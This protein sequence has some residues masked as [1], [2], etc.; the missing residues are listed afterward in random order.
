MDIRKISSAIL[1]GGLLSGPAAAEQ[2]TK[3]TGAQKPFDR[4]AE[5]GKLQDLAE[6]KCKPIVKSTGTRGKWYDKLMDI[7]VTTSEV[8]YNSCMRGNT[9]IEAIDWT[10]TPD[11]STLAAAKDEETAIIDKNAKQECG[12]QQDLA[13]AAC[14]PTVVSTGVRGKWY[15]KLMD[16]CVTTS[17]ARYNACVNGKKSIIWTWTPDPSMLAAAKDEARVALEEEARKARDTAAAAKKDQ[18]ESAAKANLELQALQAEL[19]KANQVATQAQK[20]AAEATRK[21]DN[22]EA[23]AKAADAQA[24]SDATKKVDAEKLLREAGQAKADAEKLLRE[25]GQAKADV[26]KLKAD[27][28]NTVRRSSSSRQAN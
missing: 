27:V 20:D 22:L 10:Y 8:R 25:A 19:T 21:A 13:E 9:P 15:D 4:K 14:K 7:C 17:E 18:E 6:A 28:Q 16:I 26:D 11:P 23:A 24:K 5:C 12:K 1:I 3:N 2:T